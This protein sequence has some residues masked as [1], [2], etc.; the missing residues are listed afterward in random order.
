MPID[1]LAYNGARLDQSLL[2]ASANL[3]RM[4]FTSHTEIPFRGLGCGHR[5]FRTDGGLYALHPRY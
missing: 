3:D 1:F 5:A 4:I 2:P